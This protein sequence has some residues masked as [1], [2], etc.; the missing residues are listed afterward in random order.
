MSFRYMQN[1]LRQINVKLLDIST[2]VGVILPTQIDR[3]SQIELVAVI[4]TIKRNEGG[5]ERAVKTQITIAVVTITFIIADS[6]KT[7][8]TS[9][10]IP[11]FVIILVISKRGSAFGVKFYISED[12]V[13]NQFYNIPK[14][15][16]TNRKLFLIWKYVFG[17]TFNKDIHYTG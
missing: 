13:C 4:D 11:Q 9:C 3:T 16:R 6:A 2:C 5:C 8:R 7:D 14:Q 15:V 17:F 1:S 10:S 12:I